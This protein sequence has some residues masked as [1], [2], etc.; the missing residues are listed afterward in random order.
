MT[1]RE[2]ARLM[3]VPDDFVIDVPD[4]QAYFGFGDAVCVPAVQWIAHHVLNPL[5]GGD[6]WKEAT[7]RCLI[8]A[9][10]NTA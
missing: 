5:A 1:P 4:N 7:S 9:D 3:G 8:P 6:T 10:L 2:Y